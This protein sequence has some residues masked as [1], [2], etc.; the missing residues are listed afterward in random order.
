MVP[1]VAFPCL[2][3][4][5][6][7]F[8][9]WFHYNSSWNYKNCWWIVILCTLYAWHLCILDFDTDFWLYIILFMAIPCIV[10]LTLQISDKNTLKIVMYSIKLI[11]DCHILHSIC[12]EL[13]YMTTD[14]DFRG[15][16]VPVM[17][18]PC[19]Q[20][21]VWPSKMIGL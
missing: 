13:A 18:V 20:V 16:K 14:N 3:I 7:C 12:S 9:N 11:E 8:Q 15:W 5:A 21:A 19:I 10:I 17:A 1:V 4:P 6:G 2:F